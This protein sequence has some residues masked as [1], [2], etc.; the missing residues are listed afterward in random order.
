MIMHMKTTIVCFLLACHNGSDANSQTALSRPQ[1]VA[2]ALFKASIQQSNGDCLDTFANDGFEWCFEKEGEILVISPIKRSGDTLHSVVH[3]A[4]HAELTSTAIDWFTL[5]NQ[6][7]VHGF[8]VHYRTVSSIK[9]SVLAKI[10]GATI[11]LYCPSELPRQSSSVSVPLQLTWFGYASRSNMFGLPRWLTNADS[12]TPSWTGSH[13]HADGA[14]SDTMV[15]QVAMPGL[16]DPLPQ[17]EWLDR[18]QRML[19]HLEKTRSLSGF[20]GNSQDEMLYGEITTEGAVKAFSAIDLNEKDTLYD[21]GSG[22]GKVVVLAAMLSGGRAIG[23]ELDS[24]RHAAA[25]RALTVS[26]S[27]RWISE[28]E[29]TLINLRQGDAFAHRAFY[30]ATVIYM[31]S[32]A[33]RDE[34]LVRFLCQ[35]VHKNDAPHLRTIMTSRPLPVAALRSCENHNTGTNVQLLRSLQIPTTWNPSSMIHIYSVTYT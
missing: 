34:T 5:S 17:S 21:L 13:T 20:R 18:Y 7:L 22:T 2:L 33:F 10:N 12:M 6:Q 1:L 27:S 35:G 14:M 25:S 16:C 8:E 24:E 4:I 30:D 28:A 26:T 3:E 9:H 23:I 15:M 11:K 19:N 31:L 29:A 32:V